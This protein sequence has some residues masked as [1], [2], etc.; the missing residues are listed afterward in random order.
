[1]KAKTS[2]SWL[3][4]SAA[5]AAALIFA[6]PGSGVSWAGDASDHER[7]RQALEAG[8]I[9]PL[10]TILERVERDNPGQVMEV[11]LERSRGAW[12]YEVKLLRKDGALVKLKVDARDGKVLGSK[13]TDERR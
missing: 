12:I 7:A 8:E 1:M 10:R 6:V 11:E 5:L 3:M 4:A 2:I 9:L 13:S